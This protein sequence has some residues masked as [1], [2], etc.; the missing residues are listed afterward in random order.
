MSGHR[1]ELHISFT[2][3]DGNDGGRT[4]AE[5]LL[6][7]LESLADHGEFDRYTGDFTVSRGTVDGN[8]W[9]ERWPDKK[10]VRHLGVLNPG[11]LITVEPGEFV[12]WDE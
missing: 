6:R 8:A 9:T 11:D 5:G 10:P 4:A 1:V 3:D 12:T 7:R 2:A